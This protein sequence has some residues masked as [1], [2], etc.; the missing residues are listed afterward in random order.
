MAARLTIADAPAHCCRRCEFWC[1]E[2][3]LLAIATAAMAPCLSP[4]G[5]RFVPDWDHLCPAFSEDGNEYE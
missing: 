3:G 1:P 5:D 2:G 4:L